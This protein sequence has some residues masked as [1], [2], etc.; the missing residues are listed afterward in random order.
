L[1]KQ[2]K[3][4]EDQFASIA[5]TYHFNL[6]NIINKIH[7][8]QWDVLNLVADKMAKSMMD[9]G[10][11]HLFGSGHS[12]LPVEEAFFRSGGLAPMNP[13]FDPSLML[14]EGIAKIIKLE[15]L[16]RYTETI[17]N[18]YDVQEGEVLI[19]FSASGK[20]AAPIDMALEGKKRGLTTIAVTS[21]DYANY[22]P[23]MHSSGKHLHEVVDY[24]LDSGAPFGDV[25]VRDERLP[26]VGAVG[27][28]ATITSLYI[29]NLLQMLVV[30]RYLASGKE[31][32]LT[33]CFNTG[34]AEAAEH[35]KKSYQ[36]IENRMRHL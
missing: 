9:D 20:N 33:V 7:T 14:H 17:W 1:S 32:P 18:N 5:E 28:G 23:S 21:L 22:T 6:L 16:E 4:E 27:A 34:E 29:V 19:I 3:P 31:P 30:D 15:R 25:L 35:N 12:H 26:G 11:V 10:L 2:N 13:L 24:V 8:T 36:S